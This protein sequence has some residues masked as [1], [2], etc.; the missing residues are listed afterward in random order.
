M[1]QK[2]KRLTKNDFKGT[3]AKV[4]FRGNLLDVASI[5]SEQ[6]RF[7]CV[8]SKKKIATAVGRNL[9]RRKVYHALKAIPSHHKGLFIIYPKKI[10]KETPFAIISDE[11]I[12]AFATLQ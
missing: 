9:V 12:R 10:P 4:F 8:I 11:I 6:Q 3:H 2:K 7:T 1:L 5:P